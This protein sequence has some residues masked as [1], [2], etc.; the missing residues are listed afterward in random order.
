MWLTGPQVQ[1]HKGIQ[2]D[3]NPIVC[4][5]ILLAAKYEVS[6]LLLYR[7]YLVQER[8]KWHAD[9]PTTHVLT[10]V[11]FTVDAQSW[12]ACIV[13][14]HPAKAVKKSIRTVEVAK[15]PTVSVPTV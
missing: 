7:G 8:G 6:M 13:T 2:S 9:C 3:Q 4:I 5:E 11:V 12:L 10:A 14:A 15:A 1:L